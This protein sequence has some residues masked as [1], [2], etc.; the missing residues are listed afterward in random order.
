MLETDGIHRM[1][2]VLGA[3]LLVAAIWNHISYMRELRQERAD[4]I[5]QGFIHGQT[6]YP[7]SLG[8]AIA[9]LLLGLV[10]IM[11]MLMRSGPFN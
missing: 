11:G 6:P 1:L 2:V 4:L 5:A 10:V 9:L 7:F 8:T 3:L